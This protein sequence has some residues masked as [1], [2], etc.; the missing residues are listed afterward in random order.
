MLPF[1]GL[2]AFVGGGIGGWTG[3]FFFHVSFLPLACLNY[4]RAWASGWLA[5][6]MDASF[7]LLVVVMFWRWKCTWK[8]TRHNL[9]VLIYV[10]FPCFS[11]RRRRDWKDGNCLKV[12]Y[13]CIPPF[14]YS[15]CT[16]LTWVVVVRASTGRRN[17]PCTVLYEEVHGCQKGARFAIAVDGQKG[18]KERKRAGLF[19]KRGYICMYVCAMYMR[20]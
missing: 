11:C 2:P 19:C 12:W 18:K 10:H 20:I 17:V 4:I 8:P 7:L 3:R 13:S 16:S 1:K 6:W 5:G 9:D 15:R 14:S